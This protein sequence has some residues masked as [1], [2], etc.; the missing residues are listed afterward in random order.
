MRN[1]V[2][3]F[4]SIKMMRKKN[5]RIRSFFVCSFYFDITYPIRMKYMNSEVRFF[6]RAFVQ[7]LS[8]VKN[9]IIVETLW[10]RVC[11]IEMKGTNEKRTDLTIH[12]PPPLDWQEINDLISQSPCF[13]SNVFLF[14]A[15]TSKKKK[16]GKLPPHKYFFACK[17]IVCYFFS[18]CSKFLLWYK[19][20]NFESKIINYIVTTNIATKIQTNVSEKEQC[21]TA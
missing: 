4:L 9:L 1:Q 11:N 3:Y 7:T 6:I 16:V 18:F 20:L 13:F 21:T 19:I 15:E 14:F 17:V 2:I 12:F 10:Y 5:C 8:Q